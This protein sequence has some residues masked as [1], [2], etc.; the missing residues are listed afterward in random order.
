M[1]SK[2]K[3]VIPAAG[4]SSRY[5][6]VP[7]FLQRHPTGHLM[8]EKAVLSMGKQLLSEFDEIIVI[9][10][11]DVLL[12]EK[13]NAEEMSL[14]LE[15]EF[16]L[17]TRFHLLNFQTRSM[18]E[19]I[20]A[21]IEEQ[22]EDSSFVIRDSDNFVEPSPLPSPIGSNFLVFADLKKFTDIS[23][24]NKGF[25]E[26]DSFGGVIGLVEK[27]I[28]GSL[29]YVGMAG[30]DSYSRFLY[31]ARVLGDFPPEKY[32]TD[33]IRTLVSEGVAFRAVECQLFRDWG[34]AKEWS[35]EVNSHRQ[36]ICDLEGFLA[37][38][39][40]LPRLN[41]RD[42]SPTGNLERLRIRLDSFDDAEAIIMTSAMRP[43]QFPELVSWLAS[44][45]MPTEKCKILFASTGVPRTTLGQDLI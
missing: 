14:Q 45:A 12:D 9:T 7:K 32:V 18:V 29:I 36:F 22:V 15:R 5:S 38:A 1:K 10:R 42:L 21:F 2:S 20:V 16:G 23:A 30:F 28:I 39:P 26:V 43:E 13:I 44:H 19:T 33:V 3:L 27:E 4:L 24:A 8:V 31:A 17:P 37:S 35:R 40:N 41:T 34:T 25:V 11:Q 6:G